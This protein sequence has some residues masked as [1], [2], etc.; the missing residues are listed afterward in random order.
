L[1]AT[2]GSCI[3]SIDIDLNFARR[4]FA[5]DVENTPRRQGRRSC[6]VHVCFTSAAHANVQVGGCQM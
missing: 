1:A 2:D 4:Q 5:D 3:L 6:F